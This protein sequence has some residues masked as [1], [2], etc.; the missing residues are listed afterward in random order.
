M[1]GKVLV[2]GHGYVGQAYASL[3]DRKYKTFIQDPYKGRQVERD[4]MKLCNLA[5]ICVPTP[6]LPN[7]RCDTSIVEQEIEKLPRDISLVMIKSTI[8]PGTTA[9]LSK[10]FNRSLVFSPEYIG[11]GGYWTP[12]EFPNPNDPISH[13]FVILGS[14]PM[15]EGAGSADYIIDMM[16]PIVGP[17]TKFRKMT[18]TDAELVKYFENTFFALKVTFANEMRDICNH[19]GASYHT[20]REGWLDD[21]RNGR[22]HSAAFAHKPGFDGK[23]LPK[24]TE[25]LLAV[26]A[27]TGM[28][29]ALIEALVEA[30]KSRLKADS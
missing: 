27:S 15:A 2:V 3:F 28:R 7:G 11:E 4:I 24:D 17:S 8:E 12:P 18:S 20:V 6:M 9:R 26:C 23:C 5:I 19:F 30:N 21:P 22:S 14:S 16:M 29:P 25:A 10:L 13:G 1:S